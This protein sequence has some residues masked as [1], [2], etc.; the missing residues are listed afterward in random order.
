[1]LI[2]VREASSPL[3]DKTSL[4][5]NSNIVGGK[6]AGTMPSS[7]EIEMHLS[8]YTINNIVPAAV[9]CIPRSNIISPTHPHPP[10][11]VSLGKHTFPCQKHCHLIFYQN[12]NGHEHQQN[13]LYMLEPELIACDIYALH[14]LC[15]VPNTMAMT[16][17]SSLLRRF[18]A[19]SRS[20]SATACA[21][22]LE[23]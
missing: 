10:R 7:K 21:L 16:E 14:Q 12:F 5:P 11:R 6:A 9:Q 2:G 18:C 19:C 23:L 3:T 1:M 15:S 4:K 13:I 22:C 17:M 8:F 20:A